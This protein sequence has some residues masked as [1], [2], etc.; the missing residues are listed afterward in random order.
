LKDLP[1]SVISELTQ[2]MAL[3]LALQVNAGQLSLDEAT[4]TEMAKA[5]WNAIAR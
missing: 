1:L 4:L 2:G 5:C 3:R